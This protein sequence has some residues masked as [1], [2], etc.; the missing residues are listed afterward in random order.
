MRNLSS[1]CDVEMWYEASNDSIWKL[2]FLPNTVNCR[3]QVLDLYIFVRGF[4]N[5]YKQR[6]LYPSG[7]ITEIEK[8]PWRKL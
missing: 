6:G 3:L 1:L 2:G 4:R 7:L 5:A 8:A